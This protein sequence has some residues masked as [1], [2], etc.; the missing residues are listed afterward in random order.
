MVRIP[1]SHPRKKSLESRQKIV[2]GSS[3][4]LLA[5][6][7]MIAHGRGEAFDYL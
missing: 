1:D 4:G 3:M 5:D 7:A 2:D 6:S